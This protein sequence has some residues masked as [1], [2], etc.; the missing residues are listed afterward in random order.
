MK[1]PTSRK[2]NSPVNFPKPSTPKPTKEQKNKPLSLLEL[3]READ[4]VA[5]P[6]ASAN[7][8]TKHD[9][10]ADLFP[11]FIDLAKPKKANS[12]IPNR[13]KTTKPSA[14]PLKRP[15]YSRTPS[16]ISPRLEINRSKS[17]DDSTPEFSDPHTSCHIDHEENK[18][19]NHFFDYAESSNLN[20]NF[21]MS[22]GP[23]PKIGSAVVGRAQTERSGLKLEIDKKRTS[24]K[25]R[26]EA[27]MKEKYSFK[28]KI[29]DK[30]K[31]LDSKRAGSSIKRPRYEDLYEFDQVLRVREAE[32]KEIVEEER[33]HKELGPEEK[34]CT[35]QPKINNKGGVRTIK[36]I[37]ERSK[38]WKEMKDLKLKEELKVK[39]EKELVGCTFRPDISRK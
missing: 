12:P 30:S 3:M 19:S 9:L 29:N 18:I 8:F 28:P 7:D 24:K 26:L 5:P 13:P 6:V 17:R 34:E 16:K 39:K 21:L 27:E 20:E 25:D 4:K 31:A 36:D 23:S 2:V 14:S 22:P 15:V 11:E 35:F 1:P 38:A 33:Y 37:S 32:R 10:T